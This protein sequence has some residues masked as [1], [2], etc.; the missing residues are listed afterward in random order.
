MATLPRIDDFR[1]AAVSFLNAKPLLDGLDGDPRVT[2]SLAVP[3]RLPALLAAGQV[4][5]ALVPLVDVLRA[6]GRYRV[7]SDACIGCDGETLTVRVFSQVPPDQVRQLRADPDS[8]TSVALAR[9]IWQHRY[10]VALA[11]VDTPRDTPLE[12]D[13][14]VLLIGDKVI[15]A[16]QQGYAHE[17]DLGAAWQALTGLGFVFAV[18]ATPTP[19]SALADLLTAARDRGITRCQT[20]AATYGPLHGWTSDLAERYLTNCLRFTLDAS[21]R[22]GAERFAAACRAAGL[23]P[24]EAAL[25]WPAAGVASAPR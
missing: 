17:L 3:A 6:G 25:P 16:R 18:W 7:I 12:A 13:E 8:H 9:L 2:L 20:L 4:D 21:L 14:A 19:T 10:D 1:L 5:A 11:V 15:A 24:A 23:V 22:S